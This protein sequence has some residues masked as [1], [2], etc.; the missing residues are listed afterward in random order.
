MHPTFDQCMTILMKTP[1]VLVVACHM[2]LGPK[3]LMQVH[4]EAT[5]TLVPI[6]LQSIQQSSIHAQVSY[7]SAPQTVH[8]P[9][10][11]FIPHPSKMH[12]PMP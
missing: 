2:W 7:A 11:Q 10:C 1:Q 4:Q 5:S 8:P 6:Y 9:L 12:P 3:F